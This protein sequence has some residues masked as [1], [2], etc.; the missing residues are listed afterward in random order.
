[1][2]YIFR[3]R[4]GG[5]DRAG[6]GRHR[7]SLFSHRLKNSASRFAPG[8]ARGPARLIFDPLEARLL[9]SADILGV[10][11]AAVNKSANAC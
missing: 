10:D 4:A 11:L 8:P 3:T 1:M 9:L 7:L 2:S 6:S 5:F